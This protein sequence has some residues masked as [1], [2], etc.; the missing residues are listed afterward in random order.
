MGGTA[1]NPTLLSMVCREQLWLRLLFLPHCRA[2]KKG[3]LNTQA[4]ALAEHAL[5]SVAQAAWGL[6]D[7]NSTPVCMIRIF[8]LK[9]YIQFLRQI[10]H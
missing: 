3:F 6:R 9:K 5:A 2:K 1:G 7:Q 8:I 10:L 4:Q